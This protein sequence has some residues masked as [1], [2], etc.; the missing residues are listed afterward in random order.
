M[1]HVLCNQQLVQSEGG[2][3]T[4]LYGVLKPGTGEF[5]WASAGHPNPILHRLAEDG[6]EVLGSDGATGLPIGI[7]DDVEYETQTAILPPK[8]RLMVYTDGI[9][10]AFPAGASHHEEFGLAGIQKTLSSSRGVPSSR[11]CNSCLTIQ[12]HLLRDKGD[13]TTHQWCCWNAAK[14]YIRSQLF[15]SHRHWSC[16]SRDPYPAPGV[17]ETGLPT[18]TAGTPATVQCGGTSLRT[19]LPAPTLAP[20]RFRHFPKSSLPLQSAHRDEPLR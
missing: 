17:L 19:T 14:N 11:F 12:M 3:I 13:T 1:N 18:I 5:R 10:E 20:R 2:F 7:L 16:Q 15:R 6:F 4:L 8:C 9:I